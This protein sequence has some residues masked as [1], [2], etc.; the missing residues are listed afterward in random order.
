MRRIL[1]HPNSVYCVYSVDRRSSEMVQNITVPSVAILGIILYLLLLR[2]AYTP[3]E[4]RLSLQFND[5]PYN[6]V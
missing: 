3:T 4:R 1:T 5:F 2:R 6:S